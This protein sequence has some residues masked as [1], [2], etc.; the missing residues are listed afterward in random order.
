MS[1]ALLH[2]VLLQETSAAFTQVLVVQVVL[3]AV[4]LVMDCLFF[5]W[6]NFVAAILGLLSVAGGYSGYRDRRVGFLTV[7]LGCQ[8]LGLLVVFAGAMAS[9]LNLA[10]YD[11]VRVCV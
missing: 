7:F 9:Y 4:G 2:Q 6:Y 1:P 8:I 3:F 11:Q 5:R 10:N